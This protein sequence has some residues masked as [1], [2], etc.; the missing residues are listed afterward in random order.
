MCEQEFGKPDRDTLMNNGKR[1]VGRFNCGYF[2]FGLGRRGRASKSKGRP[3]KERKESKQLWKTTCQ[4]TI[5]RT[6]I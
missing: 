6:D 2:N 4:I 1:L 5:Y 3:R